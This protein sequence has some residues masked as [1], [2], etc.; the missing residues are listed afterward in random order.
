[1]GS[2]RDFQGLVSLI[3]SWDLSPSGVVQPNFPLNCRL[4]VHVCSKLTSLGGDG[5][6]DPFV[7]GVSYLDQFLFDFFPQVHMGVKGFVRDSVTGAGLENA[8][9]GVAGIA[10]NI[11]AG[12]FG[13]Y[14]RLLVPGTYN[15]TAAVRG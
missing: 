1:M 10:H 9:I 13:D 7:P 5:G 6:K 3:S 4:A 15:I 11:T 2:T 12:R 14:H 8:T